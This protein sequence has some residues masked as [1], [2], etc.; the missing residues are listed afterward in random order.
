MVK[1]NGVPICAVA[2]QVPIAGLR[3]GI[4]VGRLASKVKLHVA[5]YAVAKVPSETLTCQENSVAALPLSPSRGD[6]GQHQLRAFDRME[7]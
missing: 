2:P 1:A 7:P 5:E 4:E 3:S 6:F